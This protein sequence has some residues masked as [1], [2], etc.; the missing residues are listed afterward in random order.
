M[1]V[2]F[3]GSLYAQT[4]QVKLLPRKPIIRKVDS[5][6]RFLT[7]LPENFATCQYGFFCKQ[8]LK[9]EKEIKVPIKFRLG[10]IEYTNWLEGKS[11]FKPAN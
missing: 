7:L 3:F 4:P 9:L 2:C 6:Y 5:V 10:S 1:L 11:R 8:E